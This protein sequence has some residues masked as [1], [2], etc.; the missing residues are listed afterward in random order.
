MGRHS[1][2]T[3]RKRGGIMAMRSAG[4]SVRDI[5]RAIGRDKPTVSRE[6]SRN[7]G[8]SGYRASA[9]QGAN[10]RRRAAC[11]RP[12]R[13]DDPEL[14]PL[15]EGLI[16]ERRWSPEQVAGR[17]AL[18]RPGLAVSASTIYRAANA[19]R[20]SPPELART[21][22]GLCSR[23]RHKGKRGHREGVEERRGKIPGTRLIGERPAKT[24]RGRDSGTGRETPWS[25]GAPGPAWSRLS[26]GGAAAWRADWPPWRPRCCSGIRPAGP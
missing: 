8:R 7:R 6:L 12:K 13:L 16:S 25:A 3:L 24:R 10:L 4:A 14:A 15:V 26:T 18:E 1:H 19:R 21:A 2:F 20:L 17:L 23:L 11:V 22:R 5:A 9:T